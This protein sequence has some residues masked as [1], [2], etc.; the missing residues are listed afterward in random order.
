MQHVLTPE[1]SLVVPVFRNEASIPELVATI[2][3]QCAPVADGFEAVFVVDG[4]PDGSQA[5]LEQLLPSC[6]FRSRLLVLS[7]N[8]GA[9]AAIR[10]GLEHSTGRF[11]AVMAADLQE[12]PALIARFVEALRTGADVAFGVRESRADPWRSQLASRLFWASYRRLVMPDVPVGGV[13]IFALSAPFRDRLL[14]LRESK[15][16]Y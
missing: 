9:F 10:V 6:G 4:S 13:D 2:R 3:E 7:R 1:L 8:F 16:K 14:C 12:P 5:L 15:K 11:I